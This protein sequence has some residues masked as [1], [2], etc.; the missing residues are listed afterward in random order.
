MVIGY[1]YR[2]ADGSLPSSVVG[3]NSL[4]QV[5]SCC[6]TE[7]AGDSPE[8]TS[9]SLQTAPSSLYSNTAA[10]RMRGAVTC[11]ESVKQRM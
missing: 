3:V 11:R 10:A 1:I 2:P 5:S 7:P 9:L 6:H 8:Q 4:L